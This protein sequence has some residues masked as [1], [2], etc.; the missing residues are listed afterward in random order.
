VVQHIGTFIDGDI[1]C[2][3]VVGEGGLLPSSIEAVSIQAHNF[4]NPAWICCFPL[5]PLGGGAKLIT[6]ISKI[7][8]MFS[9]IFYFIPNT[10]Y[11]NSVGSKRS[12]TQNV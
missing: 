10:I 6:F 12:V 11:G 5:P 2:I 1:R 3:V 9:R 4:Q 8:S 7:S